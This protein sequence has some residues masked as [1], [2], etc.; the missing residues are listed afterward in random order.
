V[1]LPAYL[2]GV[3]WCV[4]MLLEARLAALRLDRDDRGRRL[5]WP[6]GDWWRSLL[7]ASYAEAGRRLLPWVWLSIFLGAGT[8]VWLFVTLGRSAGGG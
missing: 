2:L 3:Q 4:H 6:R 1:I 8:F 7:P 5:A